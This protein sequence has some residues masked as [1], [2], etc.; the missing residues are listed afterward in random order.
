M[1]KRLITAA[2]TAGALALGSAG[3]ASA[4]IHPIAAPGGSF[5][6]ASFTVYFGNHHDS[7]GNGDWGIY[8]QVGNASGLADTV[9]IT[10]VASV[11]PSFCG[12]PSGPCGQYTAVSEASGDLFTI[13]GDFAPNQGPGHA[14]QKIKSAIDVQLM[15]GSNITDTQFY[16]AGVPSSSLNGT[17]F[18]G[19]SQSFGDVPAL[20]FS[21]PLTGFRAHETYSFAYAPRPSARVPGQ[22][23]IDSSSNGDGQLPADGQITG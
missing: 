20:A 6:A 12:N 15:A 5:T 4:A 11:A 8:P 21:S 7:G 13:P 10:F 14:G 18:L 23:W 1:I 16:S 19:D 17:T 2:A 3:A 9:T 22:G